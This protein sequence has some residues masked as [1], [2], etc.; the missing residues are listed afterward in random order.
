MPKK[1]PFSPAEL[2]ALEQCRADLASN[3][4]RLRRARGWSQDQLWLESGVHRTV[5]WKL[6]R[7]TTNTSMDSLARLAVAL[8]V[9]VHALLQPS[10][11]SPTE[12]TAP[13]TA[14]QQAGGKD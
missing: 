7:G 4:L 9:T 14:D 8:G 5:V 6:E 3:L 2:A 11:P 1:A 10:P 12:N 13:A